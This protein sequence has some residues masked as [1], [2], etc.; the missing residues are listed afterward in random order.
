MITSAP[1]ANIL[2][3][4][5]STPL[6]TSLARILLDQF[7]QGGMEDRGEDLYVAEVRVGGPIA[8]LSIYLA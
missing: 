2:P 3:L 8:Y 6:G 1:G 5:L 7:E 4:S